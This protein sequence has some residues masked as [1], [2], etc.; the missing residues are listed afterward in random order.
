MA[1]EQWIL[2]L[3]LLVSVLG[4]TEP[5]N[6]NDTL[7][8]EEEP[9][10]ETGPSEAPEIWREERAGQRTGEGEAGGCLR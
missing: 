5:E 4:K 10:N 2:L 8:S 9:T 6:E 7:Y 1:V 3:L